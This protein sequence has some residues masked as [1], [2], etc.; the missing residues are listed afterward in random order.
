MYIPES[1]TGSGQ[2]FW[3]SMRAIS[4]VTNNFGFCL[5]KLLDLWLTKKNVVSIHKLPK[6]FRPNSGH[7]QIRPP[8]SFSPYPAGT[9]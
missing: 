2:I 8:P 1:R 3:L 4:S 9:I 5:L 6:N 7:G